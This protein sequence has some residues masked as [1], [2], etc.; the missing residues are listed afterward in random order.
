MQEGHKAADVRAPLREN[1]GTHVWISLHSYHC[2]CISDATNRA[3]V[4]D[5]APLS[6]CRRATNRP[7]SGRSC[8][9]NVAS[10]SGSRRCPARASTWR[11]RGSTWWSGATGRILPVDYALGS[12]EL[13]CERLCANRCQA[14]GIDFLREML[15]S[16][17]GTA[18]RSSVHYYN[19]AEEVED[20]VAAVRKL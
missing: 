20:L 12:S 11:I 6:Q 1:H 17:T 16:L 8:G 9:R 18:S 3:H 19:T 15:T 13:I 5:C 2:D 14:G 4:L 7:T 10:T